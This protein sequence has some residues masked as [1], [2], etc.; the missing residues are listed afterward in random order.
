MVISGYY[1]SYQRGEYNG[2]TYLVI[3]GGGATLLLQQFD[4]WNWLDLNLSYQYSMMCREDEVLRWETYNL[5][6]QMI[7]SFVIE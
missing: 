7:D 1:H 6:D 5:Q 2:I 4:Y 3:G